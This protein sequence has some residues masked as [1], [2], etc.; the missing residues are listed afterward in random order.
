[1]SGRREGFVLLAALWLIVALGAVGLD[2]SLRSQP[3]RLAAANALDATRA[4]E[5]AQAGTEYAR[6][7]LG[8]ALL[9]RADEL[10][11]EV[12]RQNPRSSLARPG[13]NIRTLFR[14]ADPLED[15]WREPQE[16]LLP[17]LELGG[18]TA[19]L[20]VRDTG[21][22]LN[23]NAASEP[24]LR[25]F[26]TGGLGLDYVTADRIT[27]AI[28]DWRDEDDLPRLNGAEREDYL[29]EGRAVLPPDRDFAD[30]D[31][32]RHVMGVTPAIFEAARPFLTLTGSGQISVNAAPAQVLHALPGLGPDGV[33]ALLRA[34]A[35]GTLPRSLN[36]LR[37]LLPLAARYRIELEQ[38]LFVRAVAFA[39]NEVEIESVGRV[40]GSPVTVRVS[41][42]VSRS[43]AGAVPV[44]RRV[45]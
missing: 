21:A 16:L 32:L 24:M 31:E 43:N 15:P 14:S 29:R 25:G 39:T 26:F 35:A 34:R 41:V 40:D 10:R 42:V 27:Q 9:A 45:E 12:A 5:A 22:A 4:R 30:L 8:A 38:Q 17:E 23:L 28:L 2:A 44:W 6:S 3:R 18:V 13:S 7:R 33:D 11:A 19:T 20:R 37:E 36:E 1:V